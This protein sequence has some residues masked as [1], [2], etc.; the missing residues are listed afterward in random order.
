ME[1]HR[2]FL[3]GVSVVALAVGLLGLP[4]GPAYA[5]S[6]SLRTTSGQAGRDAKAKLV[7]ENDY[8]TS[9]T[10][11]EDITVRSNSFTTYQPVTKGPA[12]HLQSIG[13]KGGDG[14]DYASAW[15]A[16]SKGG[17]GGDLLLVQNGVL[18]GKGNQAAATSLIRLYS[19]GGNGG[20]GQT[21]VG[22]GGRGGAISLTQ[23]ADL[24]AEGNNFAAIWAHSEGGQAGRGGITG[25][26][27]DGQPGGDG[28]KVTVS[29][30]SSALIST[31]GSNAPAI[32]AE[33]FG[34]R[35]SER[36]SGTFYSEPYVTDGGSGGTVSFT[37]RG[38]LYVDGANSPAVLLQSIGG[39]GG[40]QG[41]SGGRPGGHGGPGGLVEATQWGSIH[42]KGDNSFGLVAQSVG[43][44]G[45]KGGD[46]FWGGG[47]GGSSVRGGPVNV[48]NY[49]LI[50]TEGVGATA[51]VAQSVGGGNALD[52]FQTGPIKAGAASVGGGAGGKGSW[53]AGGGDGGSGGVG[54][55]VTVANGGSIYTKG[56]GAYGILAQSIG[57]GGGAGANANIYSFGVGIA[58]GGNGGGGG[59]GGTVRIES[60]Q[61]RP[62]DPSYRAGGVPIIQTEGDKASGLVALSVGG[63]GGVGGSASAKTASAVFSLTVAVGG[64]GGAGGW[65][66]VVD[67]TNASLISTSGME[68]IGIQ[69]KSVGGG[70]GNAGNASAYSV[71]AAPPN[72]PAVAINFAMGGKGG[73]GGSSDTVSVTNTAGVMTSGG[74]SAGIEAMSVGG[75][76]G[77]GGAA[78]SVADLLSLY[79]NV[80]VNLSVGG[81]GGG[82]GN[83]DTV[84]VRNTGKF[85]SFTAPSVQ[86][87]WTG[88]QVITHGNF[89]NG[90]TA[91]SVGG[92]GGDG[93]TADA[94][95]AA[96]VSWKDKSKPA[97]AWV[98]DGYGSVKEAAGS[99]I[100]ATVPTADAITVNSKIGG[101]G[102]KGGFGRLVDVGN[103]GL[104]LTTGDNSK[105][106][107][108][109]SIGGG[110]GRG[111][112][113]LSSGKGGKLSVTANLGGSGG[114][115]G[116]GGFVK[117]VNEAGGLIQTQG[118][119]S[120]GVF[121]QSVGGGGGSGGALAAKESKIAPPAGTTG[122]DTTAANYLFKIAD[123]V[124]ASN[125]LVA[126]FVG[127]PKK[128][129]D[130]KKYRFFDA[131]GPMQER[132]ALAKDALKGLKALLETD[133][134][135]LDFLI[136]STINAEIKYI[137]GEL[138][139][140]IKESYKK[141]GGVKKEYVDLAIT[142]TVGGSG[143]DGGAGG[144][145]N[146]DNNGSVI[147]LGQNSWGIFAQSVGGGG[148]VSGSAT[149]SADNTWNLN[150]LIGRSGGDGGKG[151][152]VGVTNT[153]LVS[154]QGAG[155]I[156]VFAQSV[157][158]GGGVG[159]GA[160]SANTMSLTG[161][162]TIGG[163]GGKSSP[164]GTVSVKNTGTVTTQGREAH[165]IA[166]QSVGGGGGAMIISRADPGASSNLATSAEEKE[167]L[168]AVDAILKMLGN[169][170]SGKVVD[171]ATGLAGPAI[172][173]GLGG[174]G[175]GGGDGGIVSVAHSGLIETHGAGAFG[176]FAQSVGG[177]GGMGGDASDTGVLTISSLF[178]GKGGVAG[179]GGKIF[180][181]LGDGA[182]ISTAG[183]FASAI[184]AQ[185]IGGGGGYGGLGAFSTAP[186]VK[187][188][189]ISDT[190]TSGRGGDISI[191]MDKTA[192]TAK[193]I[194]IFTSG[195][196]AHGVHAQSLGGGGGT[197]ADVN[198]NLL[199]KPSGGE[200]RLAVKGSGGAIDINLRGQISVLGTGA[201]G[202]YAQSG[203]QDTLG[204]LDPRRDGGTITIRYQ[205]SIY[206]GG[207]GGA[208]IRVEGGDNNRYNEIV[209]ASGSTI[210]ALSGS[211]IL[212][213][214][215]REFVTNEG[216]IYGNINLVDGYADRG[217]QNVFSNFG[218]YHTNASGTA[219][220]G[221]NG[222]FF[223][224]GV[225]AVGGRNSIG[226]TTVRTGVFTQAPYAT[227]AV[228]VNSTVLTSYPKS[229]LL[230]IRGD[231]DLSG[232]VGV[233]VMGGLRP[234]NFRIITA[235]GSLRENLTAS[236]P[237]AAPFVWRTIRNGNAIEIRPDARFVP[238]QGWATTDSERSMMGYLQRA[239]AAGAAD[240]EIAGLFGAFA[241]VESAAEYMEGI[242]SLV[243]DESSSSLTSQTINART[244]L[245][246]SLS[247][248]VFEGSGTLMQESN[249]AWARIIGTWTDQ[250]SSADAAGYN[251]TAVTYRVGAQREVVENWFVGATMGFTQSWLNDAGGLSST[252]GNGADA[253]LSLKH[254]N[255]PWLFALSGHLGYGNYETTRTIVTGDSAFSSQG[256]A[257]VMTA[258]ARFRGSYEFV[259]SNWY[260]KPYLDLDLLYTYMP[261]YQENGIGPTLEFSSASQVNFAVSPNLEVGGRVDLSPSLWLRPY[262][263]VGMTWFAK[264]SLPV[265]VTLVEASD[266]IGTFTTAAT[267]PSTLLNL[268]GGVQLFDMRGYEVRAE[269]KADIGDNYLSQELSA[270]FA[271]QF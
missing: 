119:G 241:G 188:A 36:G 197:Y 82:G 89:S 155:S 265:D 92:G 1:L 17:N 78:D 224:N 11:A 266:A 160:T 15:E 113:F 33:S 32:I 231:A 252:E 103:S 53:L 143:G 216:S 140:T 213:T 3:S 122:T 51:L 44:T 171:S 77:S 16:G 248:P 173:L 91:M 227:L 27:R 46:G 98:P 211:A 138:K 185:S 48:T 264:D 37:N 132:I 239:W 67:V 146:V 86:G 201:Y 61:P 215:G 9:G 34:G 71:T 149:A 250:T 169:S 28:G 154:T 112:G 65:G 70:G 87:G 194:E 245:H 101:S 110:G 186:G 139:D 23:N 206:S 243:P 208:A 255:G 100:K 257:N 29:V 237:E 96:G 84:R 202:I 182:Q 147:T 242:D 258:A 136:Q 81:N 176:I 73:S 218:L 174:N 35:G 99:I 126:K 66:G 204:A 141:S 246:A 175:V 203:V 106:I 18:R 130:V 115:G 193:G 107:F 235:T 137:T 172:T 127:D 263:S 55:T 72:T 166:A 10:A 238:V 191:T 254:Q 76:G 85:A 14:S 219:D 151:G 196:Y 150:L 41:Q 247:C 47:A 42:T 170:Q 198:G 236:G 158:G 43:G 97:Y 270:R 207:N 178:G 121:A 94:S 59:N 153:S 129:D 269:Y 244:S 199:S 118:A 30:A 63:G 79:A 56:E 25:A 125:D 13:G 222:A 261:G 50:S 114:D 205:G 109:Q 26:R 183:D 7:G 57:G 187:Q 24:I 228:D 271:V 220:L 240:P 167:A 221:K 148:G 52:A 152:D 232:K 162:V 142:A 226:T 83:G 180:V 233:N 131:K 161:N 120:V 116:A 189:V 54:G 159:G 93:G 179:N 177:G 2:A 62:W 31:K 80:A 4:S 102:G 88:G 20:Y 5:E 249:C 262:A 165:A 111:E 19:L 214:Y 210:T 200:T 64:S 163:N 253:S 225:V 21:A 75:G 123:T 8:S 251:Q 45:G 95:S 168:D 90:I 22:G 74:S 268:A 157:G 260:L 223:N 192:A 212:G 40:F 190:Q 181:T 104:V 69:A 234:E 124:F 184:F 135:A 267:I 164:G 134:S 117:V 105:G 156:G 58:L 38:T 128:Q 229:D 12:V 133:K 259:Q 217:E 6:V 209:L 68:A 195:N 60:A 256:T 230:V 39:A 144:N 108:A 145:V 49:G